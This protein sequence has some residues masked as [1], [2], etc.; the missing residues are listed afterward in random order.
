VAPI[1]AARALAAAQV[2]AAILAAAPAAAQ[3]GP[4]TIVVY[5]VALVGGATSAEAADVSALLDAALRRVVRRTEDIVLVEPLFL[6]GTCGPATSA[7]LPCLAALSGGALVLRITVHR[8]QAQMVVQLEAVDAKA[9]PFGP[10]TVSIDAFAQNSEPLVRAVLILVDQVA[11]V[12]RRPEARAGGGVPL[13]PPPLPPFPAVEKPAPPPAARSAPA[14]AV[15]LPSPPPAVAPPAG[16][17]PAA[18]AVRAPPPPAAERPS[19]A[20]A[21]DARATRSPK[22]GWMRTVGPVL[23]GT[24][25]ALLAGGVA[26]SVVNHRLSD[27]LERRFQSGTL[28]PADLDSYRRVER[29]DRT[30]R[31]LLG[32]GGAFTLSGIAVWTAAPAR[33]GVAAGVSGRF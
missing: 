3:T 1:S 32:A 26:L 10:V 29:N 14:V 16:K 4:R 30:T 23:T 7:S 25:A 5:P 8:S 33:G 17:P 21:E 20:D 9:R 2:L 28:T 19:F 11:G 6:R 15:P 12:A 24:G 27:R 22:G 18:L 31:L 13:P